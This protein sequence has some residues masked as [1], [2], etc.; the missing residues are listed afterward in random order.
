MNRSQL[1]SNLV[2]GMSMAMAYWQPYIYSSLGME[3]HDLH[4]AL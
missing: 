2:V 1:K 4:L 3:V